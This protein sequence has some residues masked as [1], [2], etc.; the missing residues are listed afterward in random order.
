MVA[1]ETRVEWEGKWGGKADGE[2]GGEERQRGGG[3]TRTNLIRDVSCSVGD[4]SEGEGSDLED[5]THATFGLKNRKTWEG[6]KV[7]S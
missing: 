1:T 4:L 5:S 7:S 2:G 6:E 3:G